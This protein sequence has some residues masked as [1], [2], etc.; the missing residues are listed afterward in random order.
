[1]G[2]RMHTYPDGR[3]GLA[4]FCDTCGEQ[5]TE[6]GFVVWNEEN[7]EDG[8]AV[9]EWRTIHQSRCDDMRYRNSMPLD[10]EIVYLANSTGMHIKD[11]IRIA[12]RIG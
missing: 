1:M 10:A 3:T 5:I 9:T 2:L 12:E 6:N 7:G 11:A 8:W 4:A